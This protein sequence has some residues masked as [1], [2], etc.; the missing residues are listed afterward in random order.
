[1]QYTRIQ[2]E[3]F[4]DIDLSESDFE[5]II[6]GD[7]A[8]MKQYVLEKILYNSSKLILDL[9][10]FYHED[11]NE[12]LESIDHPNFNKAY[13]FRKKICRSLFFR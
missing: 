5:H 4:W 13:C 7:D 11:V 6:N 1:M 2:K 8:K 10:L 3:C 9:S 12:F